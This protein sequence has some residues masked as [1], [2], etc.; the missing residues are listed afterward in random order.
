LIELDDGIRAEARH[1]ASFVTLSRQI[2]GINSLVWFVAAQVDSTPTCAAAVLWDPVRIR[3]AKGDEEG[4]AIVNTALASLGQV[5]GLA[6][7]CAE[8]A[9]E[10]KMINEMELVAIL[11][12]VLRAPEDALL[13]CLTESSVAK[14]WTRRGIA[15]AE[16]PNEI[17]RLLCRTAARKR[18]RLVIGT[19]ASKLNVAD[20]YSRSEK[21]LGRVQ[22]RFDVRVMTEP[23]VTTWM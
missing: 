20:A 17:L 6:E 4:N 14:S 9:L 13:L 8:H 15:C 12:L 21:A 5:G 7:A 23:H 2:I 22:E 1:V 19:V 3:P 18:Q 11:L 10:P 16:V